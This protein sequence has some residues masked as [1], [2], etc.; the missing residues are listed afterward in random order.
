MTYA[1]RGLEV[2]ADSDYAALGHYVLADVYS[3]RRMPAD[4]QREA[5]L[6]RQKEARM[7]V[8]KSKF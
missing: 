1:K 8:I 3:R 4:S 7:K 2:G 5:A 6:G